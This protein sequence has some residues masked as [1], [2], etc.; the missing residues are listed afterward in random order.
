[1][2]YERED[3]LYVDPSSWSVHER[4]QFVLIHEEKLQVSY[5]G[6]ALN[7]SDIGISFLL[8]LFHFRF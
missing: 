1:M 3:D 2:V 5:T 6:K 8:L 4:V 7:D